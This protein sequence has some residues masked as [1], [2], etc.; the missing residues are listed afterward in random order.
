LQLSAVLLAR[1]LGY[2]EISD[3]VPR[4]T[5]YLPEVV[6]GIVKRYNFQK[7][8]K[9]LE[10]MD[11]SKGVEFLEGK[12]GN[13]V[14]QKCVIW[15]NLLVVETRSSTED[16][17]QILEEMLLW[18][19]KEFALNYKPGMIRRFAY[20][21]DLTFYSEVPLLSVSPA[22]TR[23][24]TA[25]SEAVTEIWQ[26]PIQYE[27]ISIFVGHDPLS[28]KYAI[29]SFTIQRRAETR[30]SENKYFSEAPL[31]TDLHLRFLEQYERD[32]VPAVKVASK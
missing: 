15:S 4:G 10:E 22:L 17:K 9:T 25:T 11:E 2:I 19:T 31:P 26:E 7:Y 32:S 23:L 8:P 16:S 27:P 14:I 1:V 24:A 6:T 29:A 5:A 20:V 3:L 30:F 28:R 13:K 21:S 12:I 18:A